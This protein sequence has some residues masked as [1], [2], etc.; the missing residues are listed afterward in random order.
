MILT[1]HVRL[2]VKLSL[3]NLTAVSVLQH[4]MNVGKRCLLVPRQLQIKQK[5]VKLN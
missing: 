1:Y 5:I 3:N 2:R 4:I